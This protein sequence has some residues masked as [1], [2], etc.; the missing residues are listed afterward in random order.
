MPLTQIETKEQYTA[1]EVWR[2]L[3]YKRSRRET[4]KRVVKA[5]NTICRWA[6]KFNWEKRLQ[7][8]ETNVAKLKSEGALEETSDDPMIQQIT[9]MLK[10]AEA[11]IDSVFIK[12]PDGITITTIKIVNADD[13][14]KVIREYRQLLET[15]RKF[16]AEREPEGKGAPGKPGQPS[17]LNVKNLNVNFGDIP[18]EKRVAILEGFLSGNGPDRNNQP[19]GRIQEGDFTEVPGRGDED[20]SGR[21]G[22]PG[23]ATD[24]D[25]GD[26]A[27]LRES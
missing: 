8:H 27:S 10:Q 13:L 19:E 9:K 25:S 4:A 24:S 26:E 2:D 21:A 6:K 16:V 15:Y 17:K 3:G 12:G 20:G 11:A 22:V 14:S 18:Q 5:V 23:G 1:Y 7:E